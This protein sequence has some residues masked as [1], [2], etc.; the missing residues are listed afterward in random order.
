MTHWFLTTEVRAGGGTE[1]APFEAP[2]S[3][4]VKRPAPRL[5]H[6]C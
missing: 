4:V 6:D 2:S 1:P 5:G 3:L